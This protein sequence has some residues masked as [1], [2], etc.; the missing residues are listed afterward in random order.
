MKFSKQS[1][2]LFLF[3]SYIL[4]FCSPLIAGDDNFTLPVKDLEERLMQGNFE[5]LQMRGARFK[6]DL[7]KRA[8]LKFDGTF[9]QVKWKKAA[10]G[11]EAPNNQPRYEM[12]AYELQ[13]LFL[14]ADE[15][16]VPPTATRCLPVSQYRNLESDSRPTFKNTS[17]VF[18]VLQYWL[19]NVSNKFNFDKKRFKSD[20]IYAKSIGNLNI[21]T[22]L[23]RHNDSNVGNFL[24]SKN[25]SNPRIFVVDN[26]LAFGKL[27]SDRG[28]KWRDLRVKRL[29]K[30]T[31][32]RLRNITLQDLQSAL[33]VVAQFEIAG[34]E[35]LPAK[36]TENLNEKKGVRKKNGVI[37]F[38]LTSYEV[39]RVYNRL[40]R[41]L[42]RVDSGKIKT[43]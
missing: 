31:V 36:P 33:G 41:L 13:K 4:L 10:R 21:F 20:S 8:L 18:F 40:E 17:D 9:I 1:S 32:D 37:Q 3:W 23:V 11:G 24:I 16:V 26:G 34:S 25:P 12:A 35:I 19:E 27:E 14:D 43:F 6:E 5:V 42:R 39:K 22:Y 29:P 28:Y 38:G 15:Y 30:D 2:K 7:T